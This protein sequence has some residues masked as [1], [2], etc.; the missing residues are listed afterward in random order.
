MAAGDTRRQ[1]AGSFAV[2]ILGKR[3]LSC[4]TAFA[5]SWR[6]CKEGL[7]YER[8]AAEAEVDAA[9][10]SVERDTG[11]DREA[12]AREATAAGVVGAWLKTVADDLEAEIAGIDAALAGLGFTEGPDVVAQPP[13]HD[14]RVDALLS[15]IQRLLR[16]GRQW[17]DDER[18]LVFTEYK[19]TL[20]YLMRRLREQHESDRILTLFGSGGVGGMD[21]GDRDRVKVAFNDPSHAVRIL[22]AT[23]A[24]A[25][26]LNL[27]QT[28]RYLLHFDCPWNPSK[29]EQR[30]GRLDRHG[31]A[32]DV[33]IHHFVTDQDQDLTF[34]A[35]VI[36]KADEIREDLG[37]ANELFHIPKRL[38]PQA[39]RP[40][41]RARPSRD[42]GLASRVLTRDPGEAAVARARGRNA[43]GE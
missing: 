22:V 19:T 17:K 33:T 13:N 26:G 34:L 3:L 21:E 15:L 7:A 18:L 43:P 41:G 32:R 14:A 4:P 35:H 9:R 20:D 6:R 29:L 24:A 30:N 8:V 27:Q 31:Q 12:Q 25:E 36:A 40:N 42:L 2:E 5:E 37:S 38:L 28:A 11:D 10:R 1:R 39:S 16:D 23:D